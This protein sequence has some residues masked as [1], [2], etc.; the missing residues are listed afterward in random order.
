M[1]V[2]KEAFFNKIGYAPS[3]M[4]KAVHFSSARFKILAAGARA[5]KSML[6]GAEAAFLVMLTNKNIWICGTQYELAEKEFTWAVEFLNRF[7]YR[8]K[9]ILSFCKITCSQKGSK[10]ITTPWG[11]Y[12]KTKST[13]KPQTLLGEELNLLILSEASQLPKKPYERMLRPRL[14]PRRGQL[15]AI[16][17]PN[18]DAG[19]FSELY[20]TAKEGKNDDWDCWQ[21]S[22]LAN[23]YFSREEWE[24][25]KKEI[26]PDIFKEQYEGLFVSRRGKIFNIDI[27]PLLYAPEE[28][29]F[30]VRSSTLIVGVHRGFKN[31]F[32]LVFITITDRGV[33][34]VQEV[35]LKEEMRIEDAANLIMQKTQGYSRFSGC[36]ADYWD[37][38]LVHQL[39]DKYGIPTI[40]NENEKKL[41][42]SLATIRRVQLLQKD[43]NASSV[44]E[45]Y[46]IPTK[47]NKNCELFI[48]ALDK[49]KWPEKK[50]EEKELLEQEI[51]NSKYLQAPYAFSHVLCFLEE[52]AGGDPYRVN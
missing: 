44:D 49:A 4:Q 39:R 15:L 23:P 24:I 32:A 12:I 41:G 36:V 17:T 20:F 11:S 25:A 43:L 48:E 7:K 33:K 51:P 52:A 2:S 28:L 46:P 27:T 37:Y 38:D 13:E 31:P 18:A 45:T 21:F 9:S 5:G 19:L 14:G 8:G 29:D 50:A 6:A 1:N 3:E 47:I 35:V 40:V 10:E 34:Y 30:D 26:P 42:K 22:T 16:S